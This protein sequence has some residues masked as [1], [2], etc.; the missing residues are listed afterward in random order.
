MSKEFM[1]EIGSEIAP[2]SGSGFVENSSTGDQ[3]SSPS[4]SEILSSPVTSPES[5]TTSTDDLIIKEDGHFWVAYDSSGHEVR[6]FPKVE[7]GAPRGRGLDQEFLEAEAAKLAAETDPYKIIATVDGMAIGEAGKLAILL[8]VDK[9]RGEQ[10]YLVWERVENLIRGIEAQGAEFPDGTASSLANIVNEGLSSNDE[11]RSKLF[12]LILARYRYQ[13]ISYGIEVVGLETAAKH[14]GNLNGKQNEAILGLGGVTQALELSNRQ[15]VVR[16]KDGL[17]DLAKNVNNRMTIARGILDGKDSVG[18]ATKRDEYHKLFPD[19]DIDALI[20]SGHMEELFALDLSLLAVVEKK[21]TEAGKEDFIKAVDKVAKVGDRTFTD[22]EKEAL[23]KWWES[24]NELEQRALSRLQHETVRAFDLAKKAMNVVGIT[25]RYDSPVVRTGK[26]AND[27]TFLDI[28]RELDPIVS[29][30]DAA[31]EKLEVHLNSV[32]DIADVVRTIRDGSGRAGIVAI[33]GEDAVAKKE[34]ETKKSILD[35]S[36]DDLIKLIREGMSKVATRA[37]VEAMAAIIPDVR[38]RNGLI[39]LWAVDKIKKGDEAVV[40]DIKAKHER[41]EDVGLDDLKDLDLGYSY[42]IAM[43]WDKALREY[44]VK[45]WDEIS[46]P[47]SLQGSAPTSLKRAY[48]FPAFIP[49]TSNAD[50]G[51]AGY[52]WRYSHLNALDLMSYTGRSSIVDQLKNWGDDIGIILSWSGRL[53]GADDM[54][55]VIAAGGEVA[56][57]DSPDVL[58]SPITS[59]PKLKGK[60]A[61]VPPEELRDYM[62]HWAEGVSIFLRKFNRQTFGGKFKNVDVSSEYETYKA[63]TAQ[64]VIDQNVEKELVRR[65]FG[66]WGYFKAEVILFVQRADWG[67]AFGDALKKFLSALGLG[68]GK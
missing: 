9:L 64:G 6:R 61:Y 5:K 18:V 8:Q 21:G 47:L 56:L 52:L 17:S 67:G 36:E 14:F 4:S 54:R 33:A 57:L 46:I 13:N 27:F 58:N 24:R 40:K 19:V 32:A 34:T 42:K 48:Y 41:G 31:G 53:K 1:S 23:K 44:F 20:S 7:G 30:E 68:S 65:E 29:Y 63:L 35:A 51:R 28:Y 15:D 26:G 66:F 43:A 55:K 16:Q 37:Q 10:P 39:D 60:A 3:G 50:R 62:G 59:L 12:N 49:R 38:I 45:H 2:G 25:G 22:A 11:L